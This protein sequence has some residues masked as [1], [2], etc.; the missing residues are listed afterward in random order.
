MFKTKTLGLFF[1]A[2]A[3]IAVAAVAWQGPGPQRGA[4][5]H[6]LH[7]TGGVHWYST[8][9]SGLAAAK[10]T[11]R[12]ILFLSAAPHCGGVPGVW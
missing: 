12:P 9:E 10:A 6:N 5:N 1:L 11:G 8:L 7:K 4:Q 2:T 3:G